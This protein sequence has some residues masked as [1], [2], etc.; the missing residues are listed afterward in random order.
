VAHEIG[1]VLGIGHTNDKTALMYYDATAKKNLSLSQDDRNAVSFL[2]PRDE[3]KNL[4]LI[5]GCGAIRSSSGGSGPSSFLGG[6]SLGL[7]SLLFG[8]YTMVSVIL[9]RQR[10]S[11][12]I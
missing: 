12:A 5:G 2:Y 3:L 1:H 9:K 11:L 4:D 8:I 6:N 10:K 7:L